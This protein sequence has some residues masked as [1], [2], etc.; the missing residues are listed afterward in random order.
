MTH[1][2]DPVN[3]VEPMTGLTKLEY[4]ATAIAQGLSSNVGCNGWRDEK[5]AERSVKIAKHLIEGLNK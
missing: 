3:P 2:K 1:E 5:L 4:M